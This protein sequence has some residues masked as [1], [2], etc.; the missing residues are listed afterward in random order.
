M[1]YNFKLKH[2]IKAFQ[3]GELEGEISKYKELILRWT[4]L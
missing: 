3:K 2:L 1:N 4:G